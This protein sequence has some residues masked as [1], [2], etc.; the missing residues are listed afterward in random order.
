MCA[1]PQPHKSRKVPK[2]NLAAYL[3]H[4]QTSN[5]D[6]PPRPLIN[7]AKTFTAAH[8][9]IDDPEDL[10]LW[11]DVILLALNGALSTGAEAE[12]IVEALGERSRGA[13]G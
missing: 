5:A 11:V 7:A 2:L 10:S 8:A 13:V 9:T 1:T 12:T 4:Q 3:K 6:Q